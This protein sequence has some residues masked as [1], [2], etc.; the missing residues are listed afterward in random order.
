VERLGRQFSRRVALCGEGFLFSW[1]RAR[2][3]REQ[4]S[5]AALRTES[6]LRLRRPNAFNEGTVPVLAVADVEQAAASGPLIV[7]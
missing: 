3:A 7:R 1:L 2:P 6:G 5:Q 4:R